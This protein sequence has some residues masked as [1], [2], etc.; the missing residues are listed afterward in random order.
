ME[1]IVIVGGMMEDSVPGKCTNC[2]NPQTGKWYSLAKVRD[3][4]L[5]FGM[6]RLGYWL[7]VAGGCSAKENLHVLSNAERFDPKFNKW[8][9]ISSM[10]QGLYLYDISDIQK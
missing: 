7:I 10:T 5:N 1:A 3:D 2:Y 9:K 4:R 6:A 8:V